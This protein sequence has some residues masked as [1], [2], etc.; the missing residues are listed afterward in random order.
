MTDDRLRMMQA[1]LESM[2]SQLEHKSA[3]LAAVHAEAASQRELALALTKKID[4]RGRNG[5]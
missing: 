3:E 2:L 5:A 1:N 4:V